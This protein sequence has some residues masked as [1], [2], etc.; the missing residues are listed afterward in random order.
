MT[1]HPDDERT[2]TAAM[3]TPAATTRADRRARRHELRQLHLAA[4]AEHAAHRREQQDREQAERRERFLPR[5]GEPGPAALRSWRRFRRPPHRATTAVLAYAYPFLAEAGLGSQGVLIGRDVYSGGS[6]VYDPWILYRD[7]VITNPNVLLAGVIGTGKSAL[8]KSLITRSLAFGRRAYIPGD[9]K[10]EWTTIAHAVGGQAIT[11]GPGLRHRLNPLDAGAR[12]DGVADDV[13]AVP[14]PPGGGSCSARSPK[15]S[16]PDHCARWSTP[17]STS[18][19]TT[20]C[21][22]RTSRPCR[23]WSPS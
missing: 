17:R 1:H 12:P 2:H 6:F 19:C 13:W 3:Y 4:A 21:A 15:P 9:P 10:G 18:P 14:S 7:G 8:A 5:A 23:T 11:L 22:R 16:S 20:P